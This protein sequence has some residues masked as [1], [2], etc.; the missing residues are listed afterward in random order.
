[1]AA[2]AE[3]SKNVCPSK[4]YG[5]VLISC[6]TVIRLYPKEK[7]KKDNHSDNNTPLIR[8]GRDDREKVQ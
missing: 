6:H 2:I 7:L 1:M 4:F 5:E 8:G 3:T